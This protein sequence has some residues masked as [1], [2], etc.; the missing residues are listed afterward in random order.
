[1]AEPAAK[2][3]RVGSYEERMAAARKEAMETLTREQ[4]LNAVFTTWDRDGDGNISFEEL[5]PHYMKST[6]HQELVEAEVRKGFEAYCKATG[7]DPEKGLNN[8][9]F[10]G[11]TKSMSDASV[12]TRYVMSVKGLTKEP[13][14]MNANFSVIKAYEDKSLKDIANAPPN[15]IQGIA[16]S[17]VAPLAALGINTVRDLGQWKFYKIAHAIVTLAEKEELGS[18]AAGSRMNIQNALDP[19]FETCSLKD[20]LS[21]PLSALSTLPPKIDPLLAELRIKTI[22]SLGNR[23]TFAWAAAIS[24]LAEWQHETS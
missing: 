15:A 12:A 10:R 13:Y 17:S 11:W 2:R 18:T 24:E 9:V 19:E 6:N 20:L 23:K 22:E 8:E 16:D 21:L 1:M 3:V 14:S 5:L 7:S 4:M